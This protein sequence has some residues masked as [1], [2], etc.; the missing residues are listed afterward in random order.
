MIKYL[1]GGILMIIV[2]LGSLDFLYYVFQSDIY[3]TE[4]VENNLILRD[5]VHYNPS[6]LYYNGNYYNFYTI[7]SSIPVSL[8]DIVST[9]GIPLIQINDYTNCYWNV[10]KIPSYE[11][12]TLLYAK[13]GNT[14]GYVIGESPLKPLIVNE[15]LNVWS[16]GN[17]V[18]V[19][20]KNCGNIPVYYQYIIIT[21]VEFCCIIVCNQ[22]FW[23]YN[24]VSDYVSIN[25]WFFPGI[26]ILLRHPLLI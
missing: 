2:M 24:W 12:K 6:M 23:Y 1:L 10:T 26:V 4:Y 21:G 14:Q 7:N 11:E 3:S 13:I 25:S 19:T 17:E 8:E 9:N 16:S 15:K 20:A 5:Y 22:S 18:Y